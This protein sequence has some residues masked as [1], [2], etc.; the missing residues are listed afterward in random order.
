MP[1]TGGWTPVTAGDDHTCATH[2]GGTL[3]CWGD[4]ESGQLGIGN[5]VDQ[6]LPQQVTSITRPP[7]T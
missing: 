4:N 3:W 2:T 1:G 7:A 5:N 6:N